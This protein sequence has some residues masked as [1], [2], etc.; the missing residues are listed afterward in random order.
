MRGLRPAATPKPER[1]GVLA[2]LQEQ[3]MAD[4][5]QGIMH[6]LQLDDELVISDTLDAALRRIRSGYAPRVLLLDLAD[7][8]APIAEVNTART[9]GGTE[10]KLVALGIVNDVTL[11]RDLLAA[12]ANDYLV[13]PPTR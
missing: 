11:F 4:R 13:K 6:E 1:A 5:L 2:V 9:V 8:A 10:L 3:P 7:S 12:G